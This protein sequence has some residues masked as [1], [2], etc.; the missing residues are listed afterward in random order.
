M[1]S[2]SAI[3]TPLYGEFD[4]C[5]VDFIHIPESILNQLFAALFLT[6]AGVFVIVNA[7]L[8]DALVLR[9]SEQVMLAC[10]AILLIVY[11]I[12]RHLNSVIWGLALVYGLILIMVYS[13][14]QWLVSMVHVFSAFCLLYT[15]R[16]LRMERRQ[17][18]AA[19]LM[20]ILGTVVVLP[21]SCSL[22]DM[23]H[24]IH[25]GQLHQDMLFHASIAAMIKHYGIASTGLNGL[26]E[27]PYHVFSHVLMAGLS[28]LSGVATIE[29][30]GIA[31]TA[32]FV[33][34]L[35]YSA[36]ACR[37][38]LDKAGQ[39]N[40]LLSWSLV[41]I[42]LT[43]LPVLL[44]PWGLWEHYFAS[45][46]YQI[47]LSL[48]LL[49]LPLLFKARLTVSDL[50]LILFLTAFI[51]GAKISVG[52]IYAGLWLSRAIFVRGVPMTFV[53]IGALSAITVAVFV[54]FEPVAAAG[55]SMEIDPFDFIRNYSANGSS[56]GELTPDASFHT[57]IKAIWAILSFFL[58]HFLLSWIVIGYVVYTR[59]MRGLLNQPVS[60]YSLVAV[61]AG[62]MI[63][64]LFALPGGSVY[65]F[66]NVALFVALPSVVALLLH[67]A[68]DLPMKNATI[69]VSGI[70]LIAVSTNHN[71]RECNRFD[72]PSNPLIDALT[73]IRDASSVNLVVKLDPEAEINNPISR[74]IARPFVFPAVSE[75]PWIGVITANDDCL[76]HDYGYAQYGITDSRQQVTAQPQLLPG[77]RTRNMTA[78]LHDIGSK[79][80]TLD[81]QPKS[82]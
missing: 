36:V 61:G 50:L 33:P 54:V 15:V 78:V 71:W 82:R 27:I 5:L 74:C 41:C 30:Y 40:V 57:V 49:G 34:V 29:V 13:R 59:G 2:Q 42:L 44:K 39:G 4:R 60:L 18:A 23:M 79:N 67:W 7:I 55:K 28:L 24:L 11:T 17:W 48:F 22:F 25:A 46:S 47:S 73:R 75:R 63:V 45:E 35:I 81:E 21:A 9:H 3:K 6:M 68:D 14:Q 12:S 58:Y 72:Q 32:L 56:L 20:A 31:K 52:L 76:Y 26:V 37:A 64:S 51:S 10:L 62:G 38:M 77:M 1:K 16:F 66:S 70:I 19:L 80:G 65:Y 43:L 8:W 69:L 53:L